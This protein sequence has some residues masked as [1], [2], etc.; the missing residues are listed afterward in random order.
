MITNLTP[1]EIVVFA[2]D[3]AIQETFPPSGQV[4]RCATTTE[5]VGDVNGIPAYVPKYGE[6]T[7]LP[8]PVAGAVYIVSALVRQAVPAR[9]DVVSP[10]ELVRDAN[11]KPVGCR[12]LA[13]NP[14]WKPASATPQRVEYSDELIYA[15]EGGGSNRHRA[16]LLFYRPGDKPVKFTGQSIPGVCRVVRS[17][18]HKNGKWSYTDYTVDVAPGWEPWML[19][20]EILGR[21]PRTP[22]KWV[23]YDKATATNRY[24]VTSWAEVKSPEAVVRHF[25]FSRQLDE[26]EKPV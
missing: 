4:A 3:G 7:G 22:E 11:G 15:G 19:K 10:G 17:E 18:Y 13:V 2:E 6:V 24:E 14:G 20:G 9:T 16:T 1:H 21:I 25:K 5:H 8:A 23:W 12:G 26:N